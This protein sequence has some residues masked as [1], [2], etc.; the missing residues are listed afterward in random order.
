MG[1]KSHLIRTEIASTYM[2]G[3]L[4]IELHKNPDSS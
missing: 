4:A 1:L 3:A 2:L